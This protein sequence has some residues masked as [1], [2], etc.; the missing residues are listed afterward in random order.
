MFDYITK[1]EYFFNFELDHDEQPVTYWMQ[2]YWAL[3]I[4]IS[5]AYVYFIRH[6]ERVMLEKQHLHFQLQFPLALWN[7]ALALFSLA[8]AARTWPE[9]ILSVSEDGYR[10]SVC[11]SDFGKWVRNTLSY[12]S[13]PLLCSTSFHSKSSRKQ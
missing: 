2:K 1:R 8:G 6:L 7:L 3:S 11:S 13:V 12:L 5:L 9:L 4:F 10:N